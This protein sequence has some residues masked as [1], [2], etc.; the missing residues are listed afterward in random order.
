MKIITSKNECDNLFNGRGIL[1]SS[2]FKKILNDYYNPE[3][4]IFFKDSDDILPM[5]L[6]DGVATFYGGKISNEYNFIPRNKY[7]LNESINY[8]LTENIQ[9]KL[10][11]IKNEIYDIL[12]SN[13][14]V[15]D[16]PFNLNWVYENIIDYN[17]ESLIEPMKQKKRTRLRKW[18]SLIGNEYKF[19]T[20]DKAKFLS[21]MERILKKQIDSF[22]GASKNSGWFGNEE[23][24]FKIMHHFANKYDL[25]IRYLIKDNEE[26]GMYMFVVDDKS[27]VI[28]FAGYFDREDHKITS[29]IYLDKLEMANKISSERKIEIVDA[30]RGSFTY[31]RRFGF[32]PKPLYALV[33]HNSW[34][35]E[36]SDDLSVEEYHQ[37]FKRNFGCESE[38][39]DIEK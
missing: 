22:H 3:E 8:L 29:L 7:L 33:N 16:V 11:S 5:V 14:K 17:F 36:F 9:F 20:I 39:I 13:K 2:S 27:I 34:K 31:K 30:L 6:K 10:L 23:L 25:F 28:Y 32:T 38:S 35:V 12:E 24:F 18:Y 1:T 15:F 37:L 21:D 19:V 4:F 26:V